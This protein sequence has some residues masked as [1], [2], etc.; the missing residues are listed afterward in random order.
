M[1]PIEA[2]SMGASGPLPKD[3]NPEDAENNEDVRPT[4]VPRHPSL[5]RQRPHQQRPAA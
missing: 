5:G 2:M 1:D 3:F 4:S